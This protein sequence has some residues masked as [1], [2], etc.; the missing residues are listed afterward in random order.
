MVAEDGRASYFSYEYLIFANGTQYQIVPDEEGQKP[1]HN[2]FTLN[3]VQDELSF[4]A[5]LEACATGKKQGLLICIAALQS[6][7]GDI[8]Q[9]NFKLGVMV[10]YLTGCFKIQDCYDKKITIIMNL[11]ISLSPEDLNIP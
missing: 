5:W 6:K 2:V 9:L 11:I 7:Q 3:D 8:F 4:G 10:T 1:P